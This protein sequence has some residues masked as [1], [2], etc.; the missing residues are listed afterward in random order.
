V[1]NNGRFLPPENEEHKLTFTKLNTVQSPMYKINLTPTL[2]KFIWSIWRN[3][4]SH[5][6]CNNHQID[7]TGLVCL[8]K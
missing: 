5:D 4:H 3:L 1:D 6:N 2:N 7:S 8:R